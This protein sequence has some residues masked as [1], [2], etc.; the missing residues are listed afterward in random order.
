MLCLILAG[1]V[2][3]S[4]CAT[5]NK[6]L[7][8]PTRAFREVT[9]QKSREHRVVP[10]RE[11]LAKYKTLEVW[12]AENLVGDQI[13]PQLVDRLNTSLYRQVSN[14]REFPKVIRIPDAQSED[15][16]GAFSVDGSEAGGAG[17]KTAPGDTLVLESYIDNYHP[18]NRFLR[19][20]EVGVRQ[21]YITLRYRLRDKLTGAV[22]GAGSVTVDDF[23]TLATKMGAINKATREVARQ[24]RPLDPTHI[25]KIDRLEQKQEQAEADLPLEPVVVESVCSSGSSDQAVRTLVENNYKPQHGTASLKGELFGG[26]FR[27]VTVI[28]FAGDFS[29]YRRVEIPRLQSLIGPDAP[30]KMLDKYTADVQTGFAKTCRFE[31]VVATRQ[32]QPHS[33]NARIDQTKK[34][35]E[36]AQ[37]PTLGSLTDVAPTDAP[38]LSADDMA[39]MDAQ[40]IARQQE[41]LEQ[42]PSDENTLVVAG[43]VIDYAPGNRALEL[44]APLNLGDS[45]LSIRLTYYDKQTGAIVGRQVVTGLTEGKMLGGL[46]VRTAL[47]GVSEGIVDQVTRRTLAG[48]R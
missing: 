23:R 26:E 32:Y 14:R 47:T 29:K 33:K 38:M 2:L 25:E 35:P 42:K 40:R 37:Q 36:P 11:S 19:L 48:E 6:V 20:V 17:V 8:Y 27:V 24:I 13:P 30:E 4:A 44:I 22:V 28:P 3:G 43:E 45:V 15:A 10:I 7:N 34:S 31:Q 5:T 46:G 9:G 21:A 1:S 16:V 39:K 12:P 18:G 41:S